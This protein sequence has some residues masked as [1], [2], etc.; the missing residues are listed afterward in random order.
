MADRPLTG[1]HV[2]TTRDTRGRLDSLLARLGADVIHVPLISIEPPV[3]GGAALASALA[4]LDGFDWLVVTSHHGAAAVGGAAADAPD[5]RLAAVGRRTGAALSRL[6]GRDVEVVPDRQTAA[7][8]VSAMPAGGGR[9][10]VAQADRAD[11]TL[12]DGLRAQGYDVDAVTAYRTVLR[13]PAAPERS[14]ALTAD[15]VAFASGS[16]AEAWVSAI[17]LATPPVVA[18]IGP[19]TAAVARRHGLEITHVSADHDL[20]GLATTIMTALADHR[21]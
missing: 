1:R 20:D 4:D 21:P 3:D 14:A 16:A 17:G 10:L 12:V 7:D 13:S 5:V 18:A 11:E 15:A 2:V 8:L 19:S 9:V 6:A